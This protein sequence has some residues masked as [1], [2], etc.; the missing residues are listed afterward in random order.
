MINP[1][2][3]A[4]QAFNR[5]SDDIRG[6]LIRTGITNGL[7]TESGM[8]DIWAKCHGFTSYS[9]ART[10]LNRRNTQKHIPPDANRRLA[11]ELPSVR[12]DLINEIVRIVAAKSVF[13]ST[14]NT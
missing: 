10:A 3:P 14:V 1:N 4:I 9:A 12:R 2:H 8:L 7:P 6:W 13:Y 5:D 11:S